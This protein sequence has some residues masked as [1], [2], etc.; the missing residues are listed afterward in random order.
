[1]SGHNFD[2]RV[3]SKISI[4]IPGDYSTDTESSSESE[5]GG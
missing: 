3:S 4:V 1:M 5:T 2:N